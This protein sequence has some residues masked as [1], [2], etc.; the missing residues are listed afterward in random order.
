MKIADWLL[1]AIR[2]Y[3]RRGRK[4]K[5][6]NGKLSGGNEFISNFIFEQTGQVRDRKKV[7]SHLQVLKK[8][9]ATNLK[10]ESDVPK[11]AA[12]LANSFILGMSLV[13]IISL[14]N[15]NDKALDSIIHEEPA[16]SHENWDDDEASY[17]TFPNRRSSRFEVSASDLPTLRRVPDFAMYLEDMNK[18]I[19]HKYTEL[20]SETPSAPKALA[21][22]S[23][24]REIYP[25]LA[26]YCDQGSV[27]CP[28]YLFDTCLSLM[29]RIVGSNLGIRFS[30]VF[31]QGAHYTDWRSCPRFYEQNGCPINLPKPFEI[32][33]SERVKGTEDAKLPQVAFGSRW[34]ASLFSGMIGTDHET[35][36]EEEEERA[37]RL[38]QG[39]SVMQEIWAKHRTSGRRPQKMAILLWR[40]S[41][42]RKDVA[43]TTSWRSL[44]PLLSAYDV[45]SPHPPT[46]DP[47]MI[48]DSTLQPASPYAT[49][50]PSQHSI[51]SEF[52][53]GEFLAGPLL[54]GSCSPS[55]TQAPDSRSIPSS[56]STSTFPLCPSQESSFQS[57]DSGFSNLNYFDSQN[58]R[59]SLYGRDEVFEVSREPFRSPE[60]AKGS[61]E[62]YASQEVIYHSQDPLYPQIPDQ[63]YEYPYQVVDAPVAS[64]GSQD[65]TGG[66]I[67]LS[68]DQTE[69]SQSS[70]EA[71]L[72]A[73]QANL[74][75][76]HQLIQHPEEFDQHYLDQTPEELDESLHGIDEQ[77][78]EEPLPQAYQLNGLTIDYSALEEAIRLHPDLEHHLSINV[79]VAE[80]PRAMGQQFVGPLDHDAL[81]ATQG[82]VIEEVQDGRSSL[83]R[84]LEC[85]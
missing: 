42:A 85:Q 37:I 34:W 6:L 67:Q 83:D 81:G 22:V 64:S 29:D 57:Q 26:S 65:F 56:A 54:E 55:P 74:A 32:L 21:D 2:K 68:Y 39:V 60:F 47:P 10:C 40:F 8:I 23:H 73:P 31:S 84:Q 18:V 5:D 4:K 71:P 11:S 16:D 17:P 76:Q 79:E 50:H 30:M 46:E 80:E 51:F 52:P 43:A 36:T 15:A 63:L 24:W 13:I 70:Y 66:Q 12:W 35:M 59:Y 19:I 41:T 82:K 78:H 1:T 75:P 69:G 20:Q 53:S 49:A 28:I 48:L 38:I 62:A 7:S 14:E 61:H 9:L 33:E 77:G 45:Q 58:S 25:A 3:Q 27:D 44:F 72:I